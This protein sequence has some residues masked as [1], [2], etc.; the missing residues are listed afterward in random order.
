MNLT[1]M[2]AIALA[3][4]GV[5]TVL[6]D[7]D[8]TVI[9]GKV[10]YLEKK[11]LA[12]YERD[13]NRYVHGNTQFLVINI[14][15]VLHGPDRTGSI[16]VGAEMDSSAIPGTTLLGTTYRV[17]D[18]KVWAEDSTVLVIIRTTPPEKQY[19]SPEKVRLGTDNQDTNAKGDDADWQYVNPQFEKFRNVPVFCISGRDMFP[20]K[21]S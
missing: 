9:L 1:L 12:S 17:L 19:C 8:P 13:K 18:P 2:C 14:S 4:S 15:R 10:V 20:I 16:F 11:D 6:P 3:S 21:G 7:L 5:A